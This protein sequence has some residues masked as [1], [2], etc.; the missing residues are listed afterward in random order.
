MELLREAREMKEMAER[1]MEKYET[2]KMALVKVNF[3][4]KL[5]DNIT[6][7]DYKELRLIADLQ[8]SCKELL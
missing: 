1:L 5:S 4:D 6:E 3:Q 2:A 8:K 7:H